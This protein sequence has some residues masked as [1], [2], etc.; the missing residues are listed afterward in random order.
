[1]SVSIGSVL[2][3]KSCGFQLITTKCLSYNK[4]YALFYPAMVNV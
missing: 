4:S 1:M 3:F 2:K